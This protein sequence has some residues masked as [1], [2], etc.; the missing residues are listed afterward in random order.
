MLEGIAGTWPPVRGESQVWPRALAA[1]E[2][3]RPSRPLGSSVPGRPVAA[4]PP[5]TRLGQT[6]LAHVMAW[7]EL[8]D[9]VERRAQALAWAAAPAALS[10]ATRVAAKD[11]I[12]PRARA[13]ALAVP[14]GQAG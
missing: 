11:E 9:A 2:G 14:G 8:L 10:V 1:I 12:Q 5:Q 6:D 7:G 4:G 3:A 13:S